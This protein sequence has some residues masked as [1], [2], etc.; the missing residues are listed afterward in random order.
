MVK[1]NSENGSKNPPP[2]P[3]ELD[4]VKESS[5]KTLTFKLRSVPADADSAK[6]AK[7]VAILD[8]SE[9]IR[10]AI[11]FRHNLDTVL[12]G[13]HILDGPSQHGIVN[14]LTTGQANTTYNTGTA[15]FVGNEHARL[16]ALARE[17]ALAAD[18]TAPE[19]DLLAAEAAVAVPAITSHMVNAA[20]CG[21][22]GF[23]APHK[24]LE[25][26]K[27]YLRRYC[28]KP[29]DMKIRVFV[30][31]LA[32]INYQ[33]LIHLP[34][35]FNHTQSLNVDELNDIIVNSI[36]RKWT[37]EMDKQDFDPAEK[38]LNEVIAFC[39]RME[40]SEEHDDSE[41]KKVVSKNGGARRLKEITEIIP[42][43]RKTARASI[44]APT[45]IPLASAKW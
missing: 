42:P 28:R 27:R 22:L 23:I 2:L 15:V 40:A 41:D 9:D 20:V 44:M 14:Q 12:T 7:V 19:A 17:Q 4:E 1:P 13:L 3:L 30:N 10:T 34:P 26:Q 18:P 21:I 25:K 37:R 39:E 24:A 16:K 33:E 29:K 36:P 6:I 5:Q 11:T 38:T 43:P 8:G 32:R 45:V 35:A 31:H